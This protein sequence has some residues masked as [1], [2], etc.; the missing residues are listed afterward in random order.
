LRQTALLPGDWDEFPHRNAQVSFEEPEPLLL[1]SQP[2]RK[3][4]PLPKQLE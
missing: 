3:E 2:N 4:M 1:T